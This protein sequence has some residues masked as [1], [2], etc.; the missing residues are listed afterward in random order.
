MRYEQNAVLTSLRRAQQFFDGNSAGL[1]ALNPTARKELDDIVAQI[2]TLSVSQDAGK[3]A[4]K[5][6]TA[7][8]HALRSTLRRGHMLPI[9][10]VA[11]YHLQTI[12]EFVALTMPSGD[13]GAS[14]LV[15]S[16]LSMADAAAPHAQ[17]FTDCGLAVT[18]IDDLRVA[19][20]AVTDSVVERDGQQ[21]RRTG[22][23]AGLARVERRGRGM[24]KILDSLILA[25]I[26]DNA[27]LRGEWRSAKSVKQKPGP[28][29]GAQSAP[30]T[31]A[32]PAAA[33]VNVP[34]LVPGSTSPVLSPVPLPSAA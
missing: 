20:N 2:T 18:F 17:T 29:A 19:A 30:S 24:L 8:S 22:A 15:A 25:Q 9:A 5:G 4:G 10:Q 16:A 27:Q 12:P 33:P 34:A 26:G 13:A 3:R 28:S 32:R 1:S 14:T 21:V 11:K 23:T 6:E 7:R 31:S